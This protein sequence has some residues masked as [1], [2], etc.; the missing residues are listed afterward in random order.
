MNR[1]QAGEGIDFQEMGATA[2]V[3]TEVHPA[4]IPATEKAPDRQRQ[5]GAPFSEGTGNRLVLYKM[6][7]ILFGMVRVNRI[8]DGPVVDFHDPDDAGPRAIAEDTDRKFA[9]G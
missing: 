5:I 9:T 3:A 7:V 2:L 6:F 4:G 8:G 1:V